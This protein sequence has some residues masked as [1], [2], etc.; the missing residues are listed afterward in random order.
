[1]TELFGPY[2]G[3]IWVAV[4]LFV[5]FVTGLIFGIFDNTIKKDIPW[6][7][8]GAA[9][10]PSQW[11]RPTDDTWQ[12]LPPEQIEFIQ[13]TGMCP[14]C[15]TRLYGGP[16]GGASVNLFC[17]NPDCD[18]RFNVGLH[19]LPFGEF[20]GRT[21]PDFQ[22]WLKS[23]EQKVELSVTVDDRVAEVLNR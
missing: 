9:F 1:M 17:G 15:R 6:E 20:T 19:G 16:G 21:P 10:M 5:I 11:T 14:Y 13:D 23:R 12:D 8:I 2:Y 7:D 4:F 18:S 3:F 22:E